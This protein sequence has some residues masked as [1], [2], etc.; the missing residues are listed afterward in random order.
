VIRVRVTPGRLEVLAAPGSACGSHGGSSGTSGTKLHRMID[1][2]EE[3][4]LTHGKA[5]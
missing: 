1:F 4:R 5:V 3:T 2:L